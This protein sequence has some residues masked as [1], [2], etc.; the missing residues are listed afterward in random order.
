MQNKE[1]Y[2]GYASA[3]EIHG[4]TLLIQQKVLPAG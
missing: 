2:I 3:M 1:Y 4:L